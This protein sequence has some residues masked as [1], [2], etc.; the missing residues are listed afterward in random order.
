MYLL[1]GLEG[2]RGAGTA[3]TE[4]ERTTQIKKTK[5]M[6]IMKDLEFIFLLECF[7]CKK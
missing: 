6:E 1:G 3:V 7:E 4:T 2:D 5:K